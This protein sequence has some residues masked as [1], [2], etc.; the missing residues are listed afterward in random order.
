MRTKKITKYFQDCILSG[1]KPFEIRKDSD[2]EGEV[3]LAVVEHNDI[4]EKYY[5]NHKHLYII[6]ER[7]IKSSVKVKLKKNDMSSYKIACVISNNIFM[8]ENDSKE[9]IFWQKVHSFLLEWT[10]D[11]E[12]LYWYDI[13]HIWHN[14]K[15]I[16]Y[17]EY[18]KLVN[19]N[20]NTNKN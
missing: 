13:T 10:K 2:L 14:E 19:E 12:P 7:C 18:R 11:N 8:S 9:W 1:D 15:W 5:L 6:F 16:E 20:D 4:C 3:E 17:D